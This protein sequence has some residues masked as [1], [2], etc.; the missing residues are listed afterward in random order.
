MPH[1]VQAEARF[2]TEGN[3]GHVGFRT[4]CF[5]SGLNSLELRPYFPEVRSKP[6]V[7]SGSPIVCEN[8]WNY[9][10][11]RGMSRNK[12]SSGSSVRSDLF[13]VTVAQMIPS[14]T[15]GGIASP[16]P[17]FRFQNYVELAGTTRNKAERSRFSP[18]REEV[19]RRPDEGGLIPKRPF[20]KSYVELRGTMRNEPQQGFFRQLL[21]ERPNYSFHCLKRP[22]PRQGRHNLAHFHSK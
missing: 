14:P 9:V 19:G 13:I 2:S 5:Q 10:E 6:P 8:K 17:S 4:P 12:A 21:Q 18:Q 7:G 16:W 11:R 1:T 22:Q 3:S 15:W 20:D